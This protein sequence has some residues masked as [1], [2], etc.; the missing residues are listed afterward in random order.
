MLKDKQPVASIAV[1]NLGAARRFYEEKLG[2]IPPSQP[3]EPTTITYR[4]GNS[5]IFVYESENA[6]TNRATAVT[7]SAG[8]D[9]DRIVA[10]LRDRGVA[11]ESYDMPGS[12]EGDVYVMGGVRIAWFKDPD[13]NIH[14]IVNG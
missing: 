1:K 10:S 9:A 8:A 13:G 11:F 12:K 5:H 14:A 2:L 4:C 7:W 6:G 3:Q